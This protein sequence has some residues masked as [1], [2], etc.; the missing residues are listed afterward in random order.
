MEEGGGEWGEG[1]EGWWV[2]EI[3]DGGMRGGGGRG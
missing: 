1:I 3:G 2:G